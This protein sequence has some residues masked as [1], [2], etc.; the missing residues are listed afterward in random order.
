[1][2]YAVHLWNSLSQKVRSVKLW[3]FKDLDSDRA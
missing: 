1:M 2:L 3:I